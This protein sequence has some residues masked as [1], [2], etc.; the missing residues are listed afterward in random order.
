[1]ISALPLDAAVARD[2]RSKVHPGSPLAEAFRVLRAN[3]RFADLDASGQ[4]ILVTSALPNEGKTLT[5]V[6]LAQSIAATGRSVLLIDCDFRS[7]NVAANLG[8]ENAVGMLSVLLDHVAAQ[9]C[10]PG[11]FQWS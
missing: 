4:M 1:M 7:P 10:D 6:N 9:W 11:P 3:L 2:P 8:L 5:A